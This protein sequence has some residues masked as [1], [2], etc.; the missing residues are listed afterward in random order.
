MFLWSLKALSIFFAG[1]WEQL[2]CISNS[3]KPK[4]K[5]EL[6]PAVKHMQPEKDS[7]KCGHILFGDFLL[8]DR[9]VSKWSHFSVLQ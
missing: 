2:K 5:S 3:Q 8:M 9:P 7:G 4:K 1:I 6:F